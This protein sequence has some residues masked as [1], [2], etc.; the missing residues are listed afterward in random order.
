MMGPFSIGLIMGASMTGAY[1]MMPKMKNMKKI[2][3]PYTNNL[4]SDKDK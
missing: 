4:T 2:M 3:S 1:F